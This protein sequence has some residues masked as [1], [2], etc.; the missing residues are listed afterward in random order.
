MT[1]TSPASVTPSSYLVSARI[2]PRSAARAW[3][4]REQPGGD[5]RG[6]LELVGGHLPHR[7]QL[8]LADRDV[9]AA[10]GRLGRRRQDRLRQ[11]LVLAHA[12]GQRV[13]REAARALLV[14]LPDRR[15]GHA[16]QVRAHHQLDGER[17]HSRPMHT[18]GSGLAMTW[19]G[20]RCAVSRNQYCAS[21]FSTWP[22]NGIR[23][24]TIERAQAIGHDDHPLAAAASM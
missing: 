8:V 3:P 5:R 23:P 4:E 19:F 21:W 2:S 12:V 1:I 10:L 11:R 18:L 15:R 9:V 7:Q 14:G 16:G 20:A 6:A 13:A 24:I 22:L 17:P